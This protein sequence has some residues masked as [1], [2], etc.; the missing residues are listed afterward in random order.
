MKLDVEELKWGWLTG[1]RF[2]VSS[3]TTT[4]HG[5][6]QYYH[7]DNHLFDFK[8]YKDGRAHRWVREITHIR[9]DIRLWLEASLPHG[10]WSSDHPLKKHRHCA[11]YFSR[12]K[13]VVL[14]KLVWGGR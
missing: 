5:D 9:S 12:K 2:K 10:S 4:E 3:M 6:G 7:I 13:D 14:F 1:R 8:T 11:L